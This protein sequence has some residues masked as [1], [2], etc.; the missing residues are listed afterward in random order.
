MRLWGSLMLLALAALCVAGLVT[1]KGVAVIS[2]DGADSVERVPH[3]RIEMHAFIGGVVTGL[4][5]L[6]LLQVTRRVHQPWSWRLLTWVL[7][8]AAWTPIAGLI[9]QQF[10]PVEDLHA[11]PWRY[12]FHATTQSILFLVLWVNVW[13]ETRGRIWLREGVP[14]A[15]VFD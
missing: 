9:I 11:W 15:P 1:D 3:T 14:I 13:L 7:G 8:A 2:L 5:A 12:S 4:L 6:A 10:V